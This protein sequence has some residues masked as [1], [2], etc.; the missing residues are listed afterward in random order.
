VSRQQPGGG[1]RRGEA[2]KEWRGAPQEEHGAS[3]CAGGVRT[4][5]C[6]RAPGAR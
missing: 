6:E 4:L 2:A 3:L 5:A 1:D